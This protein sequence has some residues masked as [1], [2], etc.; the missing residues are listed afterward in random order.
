M[1]W[2]GGMLGQ[3]SDNVLH[4]LAGILSREFTRVARL[5]HSESGVEEAPQIRR[6]VHTSETL[7]LPIDD[8][9]EDRELEG[10]VRLA[11]VVLLVEYVDGSAEVLGGL[12]DAGAHPGGVQRMPV[13]LS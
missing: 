8:L 1:W 7:G 3:E 11:G 4:D 12:G 5:P 10:D 6:I 2:L 13:S 9:A